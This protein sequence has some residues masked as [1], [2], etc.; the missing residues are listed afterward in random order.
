VTP[1]N[2]ELTLQHA[3]L[4]ALAEFAAGAGHEINNP[5]ATILGRTELLLRRV[6]RLA[7]SGETG[8]ATRDLNIIAGQ[9]QRIRDMIGD[10][11]LFARPPAPKL[12]ACD[13]SETVRTVLKTFA[14]QAAAQGVDLRQNLA[15]GVIQAD[16]IQLAVVVSE[17]IRNALQATSG[18]GVIAVSATW[19]VDPPG[20]FLVVEDDGVGL[21][22]D[23]REHLFDPFY[24]GRQAGR[25]LGFGLCKCWKIMQLHGGAIE[26]GPREG[27]GV[28]VTTEWRMA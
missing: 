6:E 25:G 27:G 20:A 7:P 19:R 21:S 10:L 12:E 9:V 26:V 2:S 28:R 22:K 1:P 16:R 17:L 11:M 14:N 13:L 5:L 23:D 8:E 24:S 18:G 3:K 4:E 15:T